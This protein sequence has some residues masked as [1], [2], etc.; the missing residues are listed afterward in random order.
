MPKRMLKNTIFLIGQHLTRR[1]R[2]IQTKEFCLDV[3]TIHLANHNRRNIRLQCLTIQR[4][5]NLDCI[6]NR[7]RTTFNNCIRCNR[8]SFFVICS[9]STIQI[10]INNQMSRPTGKCVGKLNIGNATFWNR[11]R[12]FRCFD[13]FRVFSARILNKGLPRRFL[14]FGTSISQLINTTAASLFTINEFFDRICRTFRQT[15]DDKTLTCLQSK[16]IKQS[17]FQLVQGSI[18]CLIALTIRHSKRTGRQIRICIDFNGKFPFQISI[19]LARICDG[20]GNRQAN[21]RNIKL[22]RH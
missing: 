14:F 2:R 5:L 3:L 13:F 22:Q 8:T 7:V 11:T 20:L 6:T 15:F 10:V 19:F 16:T 4:S 12:C 1:R 18:F 17:Q 9:R 21:H